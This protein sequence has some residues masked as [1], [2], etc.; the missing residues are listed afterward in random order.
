MIT[1]PGTTASA[2]THSRD[3]LRGAKRAV[4]PGGVLNPGVLI[5]A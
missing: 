5:D 4:D 3:A 2:R 1:A